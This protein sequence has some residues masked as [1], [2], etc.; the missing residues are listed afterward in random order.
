M[1]TKINVRSPYYLN[2][3]EPTVP[4]REFTC[5]T[6]FPRGLDDTGFAVDNKGVITNPTP[7]FG[8]F[9]SLTSSDSDFSNNKFALESSNTTR[10]VTAT[11]R[12]PAG[13]SNS[14]DINKNCDITAVQ[15]ASTTCTG[16]PT[17]VGSIGA[18]T[19]D[20][21]GDSTTIALDPKFASETTYH[22]NN[23]DPSLV[24][25]A[26]SGSNL[27]ITSHAI[28][29]STTVYAL[30]RDNSYPTSCQAS[31]AISVTVNV[32]GAPT[33]D[34]NTSP[35]TGGGIA[36]N[37]TITRPNTTGIILGVATSNGGTLLN[38]ESVSA[39]NNSGAQDVTLFFRIQVPPG[40]AN[41][42]ATLSPDCSV[43]YSQPGT[44]TPTFTCD[45]A[46][47]L[48]QTIAKNGAVNIGRATEG[49]IVDF[50]PI[51]FPEV[52]ADTNRTVTFSVE[53]PAGF[54]NAGTNLSCP[55][56]IKQPA[57]VGDCGTNGYFIS[58]G[59]ELT[60]EFCEGTFPTTTAITSTASSIST[61]RG[62]KICKNNTPFDGQGLRYAVSLFSTSRGA[63]IGVGDF[64]VIRIA[65]NG[66]VT[67]VELH[68]CRT[69]ATGSGTVI[70]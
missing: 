70:Q 5:T 8:Q 4:L 29:G 16:G 10:T 13:F 9:L 50:T 69:G 68:T 1:S 35:L 55:K 22:V 34:C 49:T 11:I 37:G 46:N 61:L 6:A 67:S 14:S 17:T 2:L 44:G 52:T 58:A 59:K 27:I 15:P 31:Q 64:F 20:S 45:I 19:L 23:L 51:S 60:G 40:Y 33:F 7:D 54:T 62:T 48:D 30:A 12:I 56:T 65:N 53:I 41:S 36:Q 26:I 21:G 63:G 32:V 39:N 43:L 42:G 57:S 38:P 47:L 25:T 18:V 3:T 66:I 28:G 24:S